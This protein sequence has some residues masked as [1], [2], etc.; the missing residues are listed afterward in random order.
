MD[1]FIA[2]LKAFWLVLCSG[3]ELCAPSEQK[4]L[5]ISKESINK[6]DTKKEMASAHESVDN[7]K[8]FEDGAV[9]CLTLMQREGRL[10]DFLM[11]DISAYSDEQVGAAVRQ[12]HVSCSKTL[13]EHFAI[14]HI[15]QGVSEGAQYSVKAD[16]DASSIML[17]GNV[18][19]QLPANG[20][21]QH[22]GW[23]A[24]HVSLPERNSSVNT[25]VIHK[26]ELSF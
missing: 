9:F 5:Q 13:N 20:T 17:S 21:V 23:T 1:R 10:V 2:A 4:E 16:F 22:A 18:P 19:S 15:I 7:K 3:Y 24:S 6:A 11:E 12:I 25:A 14:K 8:V 26:A